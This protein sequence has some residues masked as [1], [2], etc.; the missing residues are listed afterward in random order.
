MISDRMSKAL[1]EQIGVELGAHQRYL[2][3]AIHFERQSL[4]RFGKLFRKQSVE[5][6]GHAQKIIDF[7][8]DAGVEFALPALK[9]APTTYPSAAAAMKA[10]LE[11]EQAVTARFEAM[12]AAALEAH[13]ATT[14]QFL[15]WFIEEQVE[16]ERMAQRLVD[17]V[18]S[19]VNLFQA[20][21]LLDE[22]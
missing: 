20:E 1:V 12:A 16:E 11:S 22:A 19:G 18:A 8:V 21:A 7:L 2:G 9:S 4:D 3:I 17:L 13:D 6:A 14:F 5:E 15:Q 10:T